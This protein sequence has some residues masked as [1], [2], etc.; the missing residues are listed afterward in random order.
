MNDTFTGPRTTEWSG[1]NY[2]VPGRP[3]TLS[4]PANL[5]DPSLY[6]SDEEMDALEESKM[7]DEDAQSLLGPS[8]SLS[9]TRLRSPNTPAIEKAAAI[10]ELD[11]G[12]LF[13]SDVETPPLQTEVGVSEAVPKYEVS[14]RLDQP[15][16]PVKGQPPSQPVGQNESLS[17]GRLPSPKLEEP[18]TPTQSHAGK[19]FRDAHFTYIAISTCLS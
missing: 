6:L 18:R 14:S 19:W 16:L 5:N 12:G 15:N 9:A 10:E 11:G 8:I 17:S 13:D 4:P 1:S 7:T 3:A 2:V